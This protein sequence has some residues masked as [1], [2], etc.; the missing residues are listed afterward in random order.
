MK[1]Q[2]VVH[3]YAPLEKVSKLFLEYERYKDWQAHFIGY[4]LLEGQLKETGAK[5]VLRYA[6]ANQLQEM[7]EYLE[8]VALPHRIVNVYSMHGVT[9][10]C[11]N[12]FETTEEG[13]KW[14]MDVE[15]DFDIPP[16][17]DIQM[18]INQTTSTMESFKHFI[19]NVA[20]DK[21]N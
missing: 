17:L 13:V 3:V 21:L 6:A 14:T 11:E 19:E 2:C 12:T 4:T 7:N 1:Y 10:R 5:G 20:V 9:N 8:E 16:A 15:F 18:F